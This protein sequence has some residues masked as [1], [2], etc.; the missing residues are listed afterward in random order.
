MLFYTLYV[1]FVFWHPMSTRNSATKEIFPVATIFGCKKAPLTAFRKSSSGTFC[2]VFCQ[3]LPR[4]ASDCHW[5]NYYE[6]KSTRTV[7]KCLPS[8]RE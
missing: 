4:I 2:K 6:R 7:M 3:E 8:N 5:D 1:V